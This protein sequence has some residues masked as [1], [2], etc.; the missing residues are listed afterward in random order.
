LSEDSINICGLGHDICKCN[1]YKKGFKNVK[2]GTK[3]NGYANWVE[4][5]VWEIDDMLPLS[6]GH[7]SVILLQ[8]FISLSEFEVLAI[9]WH[10]GLP[11]DY[12]SKQSYNKAV[13]KYPAIIAL[14]IA[15]I[16]SS[17]LMEEV[18][19]E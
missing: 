14:H 17:H 9:A 3:P 2:K 6:H 10:M 19:K 7:K 11:E 13:L 1:F 5:E 16:E 15:D 8:R 12:E 4:K 18:I